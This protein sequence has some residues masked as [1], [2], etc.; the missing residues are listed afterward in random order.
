MGR[1]DQIRQR[2]GVAKVYCSTQSPER[3]SQPVFGTDAVA[4]REER[5][6]LYGMR[7]LRFG[8][9]GALVEVYLWRFAREASFTGVMIVGLRGASFVELSSTSW[10]KLDYVCRPLRDIC[11]VELSVK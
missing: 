10:V 4:A 3:R 2:I 11:E 7:P 8:R 6:P 1:I 5:V 9:G